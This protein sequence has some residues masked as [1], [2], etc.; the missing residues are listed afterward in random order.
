MNKNIT[1][2]VFITIK[3]YFNCGLM[4]KYYFMEENIY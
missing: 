4:L 2:Q 1:Y 3:I